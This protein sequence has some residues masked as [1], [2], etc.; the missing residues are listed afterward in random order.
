MLHNKAV[1][2]HD[3]SIMVLFTSNRL[4]SWLPKINVAER[5]NVD[6]GRRTAS[7]SMLKSHRYANASPSII[8]IV[9]SVS[10][11]HP[12][13]LNS[14]FSRDGGANKKKLTCR[15]LLSNQPYLQT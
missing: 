10:N 8:K 14:D 7:M 4:R 15:Q 5:M 3:T 6:N 9:A 12:D 1:S 11:L 2:C 13:E